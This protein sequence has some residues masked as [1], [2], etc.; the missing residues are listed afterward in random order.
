M[1]EQMK[2][3]TDK[4]F[5]TIREFIKDNYGI[6]LSDEKRSLIY[7]RLR[8][9]LLEKGFSDFTQYFNY[10]I[11]DK[12]GEAAVT[13]INKIT[14]NHTFFMRES[15]HF[16]YFKDEVLPYIEKNSHNKDLRLWCAGCS[17]GEEPYTLQMIIQDYFADKPG[18]DT[19]ILATDISSNVLQKAVR[20]IYSNESISTMPNIWRKKYFKKY[21]NDHSEVIAELKSKIIYRKFNLMDNKFPFRKP[22]QVIFCRN[23][24]IY[25]E[26]D[27]R[28][29]LVNKYYDITESGGYLFIGHSESLNHATTKY[30]YIMPAIYRKS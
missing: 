20:G 13:F 10:M 29:E 22:F 26:N 4:E 23:V 18:W 9:T 6:S 28:D 15:D 2:E 19:Q 30:K 25:F 11:N 1:N 5:H 12:T 16:N 8:N 14:T 27:T 21:D 17:S 7:S 3:L 24:M